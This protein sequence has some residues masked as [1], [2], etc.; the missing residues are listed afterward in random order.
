MR[1]PEIGEV[2]VFHDA[3]GRPSNALVICVHSE[4]CINLVRVEDDENRQDTYG[5]QIDRP[6][7]ISHGSREGVHGFY[8]RYPEEE[9]NK[10][11]SPIAK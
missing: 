10:Y 1:M 9:P 8:W 4:T 7:S 3:N 6:T 2:V 11:K 5:R